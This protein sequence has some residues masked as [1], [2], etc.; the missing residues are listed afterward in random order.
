MSRPGAGFDVDTNEVFIIDRNRKVI[1][2]PLTTKR[3]VAEKL[4]DIV[5][6]KLALCP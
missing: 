2:V 3:K 5:V 1:H 4:I 6:Q